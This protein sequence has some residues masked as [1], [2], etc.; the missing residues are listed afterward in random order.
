MTEPQLEGF[1]ITRVILFAG[2]YTEMPIVATFAPTE[3]AAWR[4]ARTLVGMRHPELGGQRPDIRSM[5]RNGLT[6]RKCKMQW[7][8]NDGQSE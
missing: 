7:E 3:A 5:K 4:I 6:A 1:V 2:A 8:T